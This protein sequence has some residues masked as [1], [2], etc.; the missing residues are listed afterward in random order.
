M[1]WLDAPHSSFQLLLPLSD[2]VLGMMSFGWLLARSS[3]LD[4][5][6]RVPKAKPAGQNHV[7]HFLIIRLQPVYIAIILRLQSVIL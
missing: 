7:Y 5:R 6:C 4:H 2:T 3:H 1:P